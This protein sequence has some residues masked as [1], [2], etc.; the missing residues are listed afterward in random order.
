[1][2][3]NYS[4]DKGGKRGTSTTRSDRGDGACETIF[5]DDV[6]VIDSLENGWRKVLNVTSVSLLLSLLWWF[7]SIMR[8]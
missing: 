7:Y 2:L 8:E 3:V 5:V 6:E 4:N 1:M